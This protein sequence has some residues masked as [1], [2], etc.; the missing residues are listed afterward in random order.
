[1]LEKVLGIMTASNHFFVAIVGPLV[2]DKG[3]WH[4]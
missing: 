2:I 1:M 3:G 4:V